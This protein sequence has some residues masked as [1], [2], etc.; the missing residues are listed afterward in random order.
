[1]NLERENQRK[2]S[3]GK[4]YGEDRAIGFVVKNIIA[5]KWY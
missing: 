5:D 2:E 1:M 4:S 3:K